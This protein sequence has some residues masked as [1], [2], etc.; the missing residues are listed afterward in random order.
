MKRLQDI[1]QILFD[2]ISWMNVY[3][4]SHRHVWMH[5]EE[6]TVKHNA[7]NVIYSGS[8]PWMSAYV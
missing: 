3:P 5:S 1:V 6:A 7:Y 2:N 4:Y 8:D